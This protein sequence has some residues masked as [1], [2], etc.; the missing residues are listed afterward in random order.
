MNHY[1]LPNPL[2]K[3]WA[4]RIET[5]R[6]LV[7]GWEPEDT[8]ALQALVLA[9]LDHLAPWMPWIAAEPETQAQKLQRV[10]RWRAALA[11]G[12][13]FPYALEFRESGALVG[14]LGLHPRPGPAGLELG[15]WIDR[16][17]AGRGL[18]TEAA[19][20]AT[21]VAFEVLRVAFL[22]IRHHPDNRASA[23]IPEKLGFYR[24]GLLPERLPW[25]DGSFQD[26]VVWSLTE[27]RFPT[28]PAA[29]AE[30]RALDAL[31]HELL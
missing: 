25:P 24:D 28:S 9:N 20:A 5:P 1:G 18:V 8:A 16:A 23:R 17:L 7:R 14:A 30:A 4:F 21:R 27:R 22:E 31:G 19:A 2:F 6:L 13:D 3:R 10:L 26:Q 11:L 12:V 29:R 15:Y